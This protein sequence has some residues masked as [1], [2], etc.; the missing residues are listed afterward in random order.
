MVPALRDGGWG[1]LPVAASGKAQWIRH[2]G[3]DD[4]DVWVVAPCEEVERVC[5]VS[6]HD[7]RGFSE[8][9]GTA[10]QV[11][12]GRMWSLLPIAGR[13]ALAGMAPYGASPVQVILD[14]RVYREVTTN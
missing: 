6:I 9:C 8:Q 1:T 11:R 14:G 5:V 2:L 3:G 4:R 12:E 10:A 13:L 7:R